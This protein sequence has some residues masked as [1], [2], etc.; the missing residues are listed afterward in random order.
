MRYTKLHYNICCDINISFDFLHY[1]NQLTVES[2]T[3]FNTCLENWVPYSN[4]IT[5]KS[6]AFK[7]WFSLVLNLCGIRISAYASSI[8]LQ[9][10]IFILFAFF[11]ASE[12]GVSV[13]LWPVLQILLFIIGKA[14]NV[15]WLIIC[16]AV[17]RIWTC[18]DN[19]KNWFT[20]LVIKFDIVNCL[21]HHG[22]NLRT[23][24]WNVLYVS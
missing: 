3:F 18:K 11:I 1:S 16:W 15:C 10:K 21:L 12:R 4:K 19:I 17:N 14:S 6:I 9:G 13:C 7:V 24:L 2:L 5:S 23:H 22:L 20:I 8:I